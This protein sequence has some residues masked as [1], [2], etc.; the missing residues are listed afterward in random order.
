MSSPTELINII[1][2]SDR[3]ELIKSIKRQD[4]DCLLLLK[5]LTLTILNLA[6][7]DKYI[8]YPETIPIIYRRHQ[9]IVGIMVGIPAERY[10]ND[11]TFP[12]SPSSLKNTVYTVVIQMNQNVSILSVLEGEY[13]QYLKSHGLKD[14][15]RHMPIDQLKKGFDIIKVIDDWKI[16][17]S[18]ICYCK[19]K[20]NCV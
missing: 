12:E 15:S 14:E 16:N 8:D 20:L 13:M 17:D 18:A 4:R 9:E 5:P 19:R 10:K 7:L 11:E 1:N 3:I 2:S 6:N